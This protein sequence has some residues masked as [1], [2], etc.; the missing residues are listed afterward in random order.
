[1]FQHPLD[2]VSGNEVLVGDPDDFQVALGGLGAQ[3]GF[4]QLA[5][6]K[7]LCSNC[8][9]NRIVIPDIN[10]RRHPSPPSIALRA[11]GSATFEKS[12]PCNPVPNNHASNRPI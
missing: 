8:K 6:E 9:R 4:R 5:M 2:P 11:S 3:R 12:Q 1:L 7:E 10:R